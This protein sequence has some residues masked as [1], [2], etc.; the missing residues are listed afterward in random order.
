MNRALRVFHQLQVAHSALF[1]AADQRARSETGLTTTQLAVLFVLD[2]RDGQPIS[3]IA[4][5]LAMGKSSLTGLIDRMCEKGLVKRLDSSK[6]GRITNIYLQDLG[7]QALDSNSHKTKQINQALLA[8]FSVREQETIRRFLEHIAE[9]AG[10]IINLD[11]VT[12]RK[13]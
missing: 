5:A 3:E 1:R 8:P 9:N 12:K 4:K 11:V 7:R 13:Y 10:E 6:D 2:R